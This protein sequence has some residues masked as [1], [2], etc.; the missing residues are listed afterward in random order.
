MVH[1]DFAEIGC[2]TPVGDA[3]QTLMGAGEDNYT[4]PFT[5]F[6]GQVQKMKQGVC[7]YADATFNPGCPAF[8][9]LH[10]QKSSA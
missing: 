9:T 1:A 2:R 8:S 6:L 4:L 5:V 10:V 7:R 3:P